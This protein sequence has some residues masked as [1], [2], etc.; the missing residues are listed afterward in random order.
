MWKKIFNLKV[1]L[2][3][4]VLGL[5]AGITLALIKNKPTARKKPNFQKGTLVETMDAI[6]SNPHI[7]VQTHGRV[8]AAKKVVLSA[9]LGGEVVWISEKLSEG[10]FFKKDEP[11]L[12]IGTIQ[13]QSRLKAPFDGVVQS[14]NVDL[15]QYVNP[16]MQLATLISS[17]LA[18]IVIDLPMGRI[19][20]L[21]EQ[22]LST[23]AANEPNQYNIPA[24]ITLSG[25]TNESKWPA[26]IKRQLPVLTTRGMMVQLVAE[27]NDPFRLN[28][29]NK[30]QKSK[31]QK[32]ENI[33][34]NIQSQIKQN[35]EI[36]ATKRT[37]TIPLFVG[38]FVDVTIPGRQLENVV[39]IPAQALRDQDSVW[40]A[41]ENI[42]PET[43]SKSIE[44]EVRRI[45]IAH[46]DQDSV[47]ISG[48]LKPGEKI[49]ITPIKGASNGLKLRFPSKKTR[50]EDGSKGIRKKPESQSPEKKVKPDQTQNQKLER[51]NEINNEIKKQIKNELI[52]E[53]KNEIINE[54]QNQKPEKQNQIKNEIINDFQ[55][56]K[57][58]VQIPVIET[59]TVKEAS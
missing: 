54:L 17:D 32:P 57:P 25:M 13:S 41:V 55:N 18:E 36:S 21:P 37:V 7:L 44:L 27:A 22:P 20:W 30:I 10:R 50:G 56:P 40:I 53:L 35:S 15:G 34:V 4:I 59:K 51:Q 28:N 52:N 43:S 8:Q 58:E 42:D 19:D 47:F 31:N 12:S 46:L 38:A 39:E 11:L 45:Q 26:I 29:S 3:I 6:L 9:R 2:P 23:G 49:I 33:E 24:E 1:W 16:G 5:G 48:G 14:K